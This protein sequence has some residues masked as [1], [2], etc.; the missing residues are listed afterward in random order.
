MALIDTNTELKRHN[1]SVTVSLDVA[2]L[3]SFLDDAINKHIVPAVSREVYDLLLPK[4]FAAG[5]AEET[6]L[7]LVQKSA[8]NFAIAYYT[9]FGAVLLSNSGAQVAKS[10]NLLPASDKKILQLRRQSMSSGYTSLELA[11]EFLEKNLTAFT[12]AYQASEAHAENRSRYINSSLEFNKACPKQIDAQLFSAV[13]SVQGE[14]EDREI[15]AVLGEDLADRIRG[16]ILNG[17]ASEIELKLIRKIQKALA[18]LAMAGAIPY[19]M[20]TM[21][22]SGIYQLSDTVGGISGNVENRAPASEKALQAAMVRL[23]SSG[24]SAL[25]DLRTFLADNAAEFQEDYTPPEDVDM[26]T[27]KGLYLL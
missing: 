18:P 10:N 9:D 13:K 12:T 19:N 21:D 24:E 17:G 14:V 23:I 22:A 2:S 4:N 25:Q 27:D 5:S 3:Q 1:S 11:V 15:L 7:L 20:I 26:T 6:I 16:K 8:V